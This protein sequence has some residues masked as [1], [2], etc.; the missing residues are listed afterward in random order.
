MHLINRFLLGLALLLGVAFATPGCATGSQTSEQRAARVTSAV[1]LAVYVGAQTDIRANPQRRPAY[2]AASRGL[3]ALVA[4]QRWDVTALA[5][6]ITDTGAS[7]FK[8]EDTRFIILAG[9]QLVDVIVDTQRVDIANQLYARA[10][11]E[12]A[13]A[14]L[15]MAL[16]TQATA[17]S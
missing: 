6:A 13:A 16:K 1:R 17:G 9:A 2:E 3:S 12:G 7:E 14:G 15:E 10:V 4:Q 8:D 5:A 11:I